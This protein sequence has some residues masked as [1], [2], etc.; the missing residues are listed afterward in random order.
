MRESENTHSAI[1]QRLL[2]KNLPQLPKK[3]AWLLSNTHVPLT[4]MEEA[5]SKSKSENAERLK[6]KNFRFWKYYQIQERKTKQ[7][8]NRKTVKL[9]EKIQEDKSIFISFFHPL[10]ALEVNIA[11]NFI[12]KEEWKNKSV[13]RDIPQQLSLKRNVFYSVLTQASCIR[14]AHICKINWKTCQSPSSSQ[15]FCYFIPA[16]HIKSQSNTCLSLAAFFIYK[17]W[18]E[19]ILKAPHSIHAIRKL[20]VF[21]L[22]TYFILSRNTELLEILG[23]G[24]SSST[25]SINVFMLSSWPEVKLSTWSVEDGNSAYLPNP[26]ANCAAKLVQPN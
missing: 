12:S 19:Y 22:F 20:A 13:S 25:V 1:R 24:K 9:N 2:H 6:K 15:L 14:M 17:M 5:W 7:Q 8:D 10:R 18:T 4:G 21:C 11:P 16:Y 23:Y 3:M 26:R